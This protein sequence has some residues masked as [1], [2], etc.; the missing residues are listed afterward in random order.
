MLKDGLALSNAVVEKAA[1]IYRK[2][3]QRGLIRGRTISGIM[4]AV[5]DAACREIGI[6]NDR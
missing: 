3:Q 1:Y 5:I 6:P 2:I 4:A